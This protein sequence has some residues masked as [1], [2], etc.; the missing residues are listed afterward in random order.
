MKR[1]NQGEGVIRFFSKLQSS[2]GPFVPMPKPKKR[3]LKTLRTPVF[4]VL[5]VF[6]VLFFGFGH[7]HGHEG[8]GGRERKGALSIWADTVNRFHLIDARNAAV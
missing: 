4:G 7:G 1:K 5:K 8:G 2:A 6:K 3:T